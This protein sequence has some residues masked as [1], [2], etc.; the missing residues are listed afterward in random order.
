MPQAGEDGAFALEAR[1]CGGIG[2]A[3]AQQ[4]DR[5]LAFEAAV[6]APRPPH[7]PHA[8]F[9]DH[10]LQ[11]PGAQQ[12][13]RGRAGVGPA[14]VQ[15]RAEEVLA[16]RVFV[17]LQQ[18]AQVFGQRRVGGLQRGQLR[19]AA[20]RRQR[21]QF[22]ELR[23]ELGPAVRRKHGQAPRCVAAMVPRRPQRGK[24]VPGQKL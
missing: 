10:V 4:L 2:E 11:R 6:A 19:F 15:R 23:A 3:V 17:G 16:C 1:L 7:A 20:G 18:P 24:R 13:A 21:Q 14:G 12:V 9:A 5:G 8:A 22:V